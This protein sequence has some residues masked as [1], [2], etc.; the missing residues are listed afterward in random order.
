L[1]LPAVTGLSLKTDRLTVAE[2]ML[3][4]LP[5]TMLEPLPETMLETLPET[6]L[7]TD[8]ET[9]PKP[10]ILLMEPFAGW[11]RRRIRSTKE[12]DREYSASTNSFAANSPFDNRR[13]PKKPL[14]IQ[15]QHNKEFEFVFA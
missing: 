3:E 15:Q 8:S 1:A 11:K 10:A 12:P 4:P 6:M 5:E 13:F 9:Q 14:S 7:E 2:T